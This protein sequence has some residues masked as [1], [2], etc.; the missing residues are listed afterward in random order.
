MRIKITI[1]KRKFAGTASRA[2][3]RYSKNKFLRSYLTGL[4][5]GDGT[6]YVPKKAFYMKQ[7]RIGGKIVYKKQKNYPQIKIC[8]V[9]NDYPLAK[10]LQRVFG[11]S[12]EW[13][14]KKTYVVLKFHSIGSVYMVARL[15]NGYLRTPKVKKF[16]SLVSFGNRNLR[17]N[18][19]AKPID[20]SDLSTNGW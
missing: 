12:F 9:K 11:G 8:F 3:L 10:K 5:E 15:I 6:I 14:K 13:S 17:Y 20:Q 1:S 16:Q 2:W 18:M 7:V 4:I 19:K